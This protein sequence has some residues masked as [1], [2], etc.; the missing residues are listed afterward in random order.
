VKKLFNIAFVKRKSRFIR[1]LGNN[2]LVEL[3]L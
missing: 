1:R 3:K 2:K